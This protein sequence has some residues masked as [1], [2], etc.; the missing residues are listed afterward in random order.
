[1]GIAVAV[2]AGRYYLTFPDGKEI[3]IKENC[4]KCHS[5]RGEG[6]GVI[7]LTGV[8]KAKGRQYVRDQITRPRTHDPNPGMPSFAYLSGR[9]VNA[10][11][12]YIEGK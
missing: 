8:V 1:M 4:N 6:L 5:L 12:D 2:L 11:I 3:F 9:E 10:L 7:D